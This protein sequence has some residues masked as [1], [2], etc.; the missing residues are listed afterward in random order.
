M[1]TIIKVLRDNQFTNWARPA[2]GRIVRDEGAI[3]YEI[4]KIVNLVQQYLEK[5]LSTVI[6]KGRHKLYSYDIAVPKPYN[7]LFLSRAAFARCV[8]QQCQ[9][10]GLLEPRFE[11]GFMLILQIIIEQY[12]RSL[13]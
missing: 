4:D 9:E 13:V 10:L 7:A 8:K 3:A 12:I 2:I 1:P 6:F 5:T 11:R